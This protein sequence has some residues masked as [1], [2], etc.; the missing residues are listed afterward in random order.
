MDRDSLH[1]AYGKS[2][3]DSSD[4]Q[5]S[6]F[7]HW[8]LWKQRRDISRNVYS[9]SPCD[10]RDS[11]PA[12][13][14]RSAGEDLHNAKEP[15]RSSNDASP[16]NLALHS[17]L[18]APLLGGA[19]LSLGT[20]SSLFFS[21]GVDNVVNEVSEFSSHSGIAASFRGDK[22]IKESTYSVSISGKRF[23]I[24][25]YA[26]SGHCDAVYRRSKKIWEHIPLGKA[27]VFLHL[28]Q[29][30]SKETSF[31]QSPPPVAGPT[32]GG[33]TRKGPEEDRSGGQYADENL[34]PVSTS[35]PER[36][37]SSSKN[38]SL[39]NAPPPLLPVAALD[40]IRRFGDRNDAIAYGYGV[41]KEVPVT[42]IAME[43]I[44][45]EG[46]HLA[47]FSLDGTRY[48]VIGCSGAYLILRIDAI[49]DLRLYDDDLSARSTTSLG[50]SSSERSNV[51]LAKRMAVLWYRLLKARLCT[52]K[53]E[54]LHQELSTRRWTCCFDVVVRGWEHTVD[55]SSK[56]VQGDS[57]AHTT[58]QA[59][60]HA[61]DSMT[62]VQCGNNPCGGSD[63]SYGVQTGYVAPNDLSGS[64]RDTEG[65]LIFYA[66]TLGENLEKGLC[67]P[68]LNAL[69]FFQR[70]RLPTASYHGPMEVCS[71]EYNAYKV[72]MSSQINSAGAVLYGA[73]ELGV[74]VQIWKCRCYPHIMERAARE[75]IVTHQLQGSELRQKLEKKFSSLPKGTRM[76]TIGWEK[77]RVPFLMNFA[78]WLHKTMQLTP[79]TD[80]NTLRELRSHWIT[81]QQAYQCEMAACREAVGDPKMGGVF[82][83][84]EA[85]G[86]DSDAPHTPEVLMLIGPQGCGK[87]TLARALF[88]L[89]E[90]SSFSPRWV[91]QDEMANRRSY[92]AAISQAISEGRYTHI[93]LDK[94]NITDDMRLDYVSMEL[95]I[96]LTIA[97]TH[98]LG[99]EAL[100]SV[101]F[102]RV[103]RRGANHRTMSII[104]NLG[105]VSGTASGAN[106]KAQL[107]CVRGIIHSCAAQYKLPEGDSTLLEVDVTLSGN[108][109]LRQ[110]WSKLRERGQHN[111]PDFFKLDMNNALRKAK[112]YENLIAQYPHRIAVAVLKT[113][114]DAALHAIVP[115]DMVGD[116]R[117]KVK[118]DSVQILL[119][120]FRE[121]PSP[122]AFLRYAALINRSVV[123]RVTAVV[124]DE[125]V[126]FLCI[127]KSGTDSGAGLLSWVTPSGVLLNSAHE[128]T[129][130]GD[131]T[132]SYSAGAGKCSN[133]RMGETLLPCI[134]V[135]AKVK[136]VGHQYCVELAQRVL[137][138]SEPDP[139]CSIFPLREQC[140]ATFTY[141]FL[142]HSECP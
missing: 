8:R 42:A 52:E 77:Q 96:V 121:N 84:D 13:P 88:V 89:L 103:K 100:A 62:R 9:F 75:L 11:N 18:A 113:D 119:H 74:V 35:S 118:L 5:G 26:V 95:N 97:W 72:K 21:N 32:L 131:S 73:N 126:T 56:I 142:T 114:D 38:R 58:D 117:Y 137:N 4:S 59:A 90:Q 15:F 49:E 111:L 3:R 104:Q 115:P 69:D 125:R 36:D 127:S 37:Y 60:V 102:E 54:Q 48:W 136:K 63:Q 43:K 68:V 70:Y 29:Q 71:E 106:P 16:D 80:L 101:C 53:V 6:K 44:D 31:N 91:N 20:S 108:A 83:D 23:V 1:N 61:T 24:M 107:Q 81:A 134:A 45:G 66:A 41:N 130:G 57:R 17:P 98:P 67:V 30:P 51:A 2:K 92:L 94:M 19:D 27:R 47:A 76:Y 133:V 128:S 34:T 93:I 139:Y 64:G 55:Y 82:Y 122:T 86:D 110:V 141:H 65:S 132:H 40:G 22:R 109:T 116:G 25:S 46:G 123:V 135:V 112:D 120:D 87:S 99:M 39:G 12:F 10:A 85:T 124:A 7:H 78:A 33:S 79:S 14:E 129:P 140:Q 105:H 138:S 28:P 50:S